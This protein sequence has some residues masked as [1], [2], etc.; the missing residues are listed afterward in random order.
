M[1]GAGDIFWIKSDPD[2]SSVK[3]ILIN[4]R[5]FEYLLCSPTVSV[6]IMAGFI[7]ADL[8]DLLYKTFPDIL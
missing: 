3:L 2:L 4:Y 6:T 5:T 1:D 8:A 7:V